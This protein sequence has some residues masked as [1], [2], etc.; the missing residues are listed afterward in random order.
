MLSRITLIL[1]IIGLFAGI[2]LVSQKTN[3]F[4][5]ADVSTAPQEVK[6]S[7]ISDNSFT[8]SWITGKPATGFIKYG[9]EALEETV[10]DDRDA[11]S[12]ELR[13]TH[14]VTIKKLEPDKTYYYQINSGP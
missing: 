14:H 13:T 5:K 2:Y 9:S 4:S 12:Q 7:N 6:V 3:L 1:L 11:G 8:V 10:Q